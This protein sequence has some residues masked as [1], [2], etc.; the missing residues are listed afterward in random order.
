METPAEGV[1]RH[2]PAGTLLIP[3][4]CRT[5]LRARDLELPP[6]SK[7]FQMASS[8]GAPY[9]LATFSASNL[10][11]SKPFLLELY[12]VSDLHAHSFGINSALVK[13]SQQSSHPVCLTNCI[14]QTLN[15]P[16]IRTHFICP[17]SH[18]VG[19]WPLS[20]YR[21]GQEGQLMAAR[22]F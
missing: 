20:R 12:A 9:R 4:T 21:W 2:E 14:C 15:V 5:P 22:K 7:R 19:T 13:Q 16:T 6:S 18:K 1:P 10:S 17:K 3:G 8:S 11:K